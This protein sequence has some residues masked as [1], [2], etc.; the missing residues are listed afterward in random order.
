MHW[1]SKRS[2]IEPPS[3]HHSERNGCKSQEDTALVLWELR[4]GDGA[5][6][7]LAR[8]ACRG[9]EKWESEDA[10]TEGVNG[11]LNG[12]KVTFE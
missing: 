6:K 5:R 9:G 3:L 8:D 1:L 2:F 12:E 7:S 4:R 11:P 10:V